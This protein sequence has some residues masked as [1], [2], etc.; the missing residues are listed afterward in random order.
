[1][2]ANNDIQS[3]YSMLSVNPWMVNQLMLDHV[4]FAPVLETDNFDE[5]GAADCVNTSERP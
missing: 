5:L 4:G 2:V 1:M 3:N